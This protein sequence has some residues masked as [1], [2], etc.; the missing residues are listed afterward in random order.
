[1]AAGKIRHQVNLML[2]FWPEDKSSLICHRHM[3]LYKKKSR[4]ATT[5]LSLRPNVTKVLLTASSVAKVRKQGCEFRIEL[6]SMSSEPYQWV[7][8][9][10]LLPVEPKW[11]EGAWKGNDEDGAKAIFCGVL[12][13]YCWTSWYQKNRVNCSH[14]GEETK[15][16]K[17]QF[18]VLC[19]KGDTPVSRIL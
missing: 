7:N 15:Q 6:R 11:I 2:Q 8:K 13:I 16:Q 4:R 17:G 10:V 14:A 3:S 12:V 18:I 1:M 5:I 9:Y 19:I